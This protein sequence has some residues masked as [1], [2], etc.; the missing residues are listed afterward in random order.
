MI[1]NWNK[2]K[3]IIVL[4]TTYSGSGAVYDYLAGRGDLL[5]PLAGLEYLLPQ[6]PGGLMALEAAAGDAFHHAISDH[7]VVQFY[8]LA[9]KLSV[10]PRRA[11]YGKDYSTHIPE[12]LSEIK[13]FLS[14]VS[15]ANLPMF[16]DWRRMTEPSFVRIIGRLKERFGIHKPPAP[17]HILC[18]RDNLIHAAQKMHDRLFCSLSKKPVLLNQAGSGWNP[19][20][21]TKY[22]EKRRVVLVIR[23]PRDQFAELKQYKSAT[24]VEEFI[25]WYRALKQRVDRIQNN[26]VLVMSF[27]DFVL[28]NNSMVELLCNHLSLDVGIRSTYEASLSRKN[29]GKYKNWLSQYELDRITSEILL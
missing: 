9:Q 18:S 16:L 19:V 4:G 7:A 26:E 24:D 6:A 27:E 22:F 29:I 2:P 11:A 17:T 13:H 28:E 23:D 21:S 25:K 5:D 14:E 1:I 12:F 3:Y 10:S 15:V 8:K 20:C